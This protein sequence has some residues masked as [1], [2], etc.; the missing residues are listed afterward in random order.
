M[1]T[2]RKGEISHSDLWQWNVDCS[3]DS[4]SCELILCSDIH[5][6]RLKK[7]SHHLFKS[8]GYSVYFTIFSSNTSLWKI[9]NPVEAGSPFLLR[10][11]LQRRQSLRWPSLLLS[12]LLKSHLLFC[13]RQHIIT[14]AYWWIHNFS[15]TKSCKS[16]RQFH[17]NVMANFSIITKAFLTHCGRPTAR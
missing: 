7:Y 15:S 9:Q 5:Y 11:Q 14:M 1:V 17:T 13:N 4:A 16:M 6:Q 12:K 8:F 2:T 10:Q 3:R